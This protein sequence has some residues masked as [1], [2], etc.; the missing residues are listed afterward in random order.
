MLMSPDQNK[1]VQSRTMEQVWKVFLVF[2]D[3]QDN[4]IGDATAEYFEKKFKK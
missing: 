2:E 3:Y 1:E 4:T